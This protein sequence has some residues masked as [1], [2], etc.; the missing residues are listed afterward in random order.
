MNWKY[1]DNTFEFIKNLPIE[2]SAWSGH[3]SFAYDLT[4]NTKPKI[5][6]ELGTHKGNSIFSMAQAVKDGELNTTLYPID[7]WQGDSQAGFYGEEIYNDF[8]DISKQYYKEVELIP[9]KMLFDEAIKK[10]K[11]NSIDILHIDGL[12]T[13]EAVN[14]DFETW[15]PKVKKNT[16]VI[17]LH[18]VCETKDDFGVYK[19]WDELQD[20]YNTITFEH[21]HG[22]GVIFLGDK[23]NL[24]TRYYSCVSKNQEFKE[25][26]KIFQ[27]QNLELE[28]SLKISQKQN[29][30][31]EAS[32]KISQLETA[33]LKHS[34]ENI[35][36]MILTLENDISSMKKTIKIQRKELEEFRGFKEGN[37]WKGLEEYR[38][39]KR[40]IKKFR[41]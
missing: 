37:I 19:L 4:R 26:L 18:D 14:H 13:Y 16:G 32:L 25:S 22:L 7:T 40:R 9:F 1:F 38:K 21:Y 2:S 17:M 5:I 35:Q 8:I 3:Y 10:F 6:V 31:L 29:L 33:N 36:T 27:K 20:K 15:L 24:T 28:A 30:E 12:H 39:I 23:P 34:L 41:S 11:D